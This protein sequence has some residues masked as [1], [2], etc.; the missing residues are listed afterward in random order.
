MLKNI[1]NKDKRG[2]TGGRKPQTQPA[3]GAGAVPGNVSPAQ[4][5]GAPTQQPMQM[6]A[7]AP[8]GSPAPNG[9]RVISSVPQSPVREIRVPEPSVTKFDLSGLPVY[10]I[11]LDQLTPLSSRGVPEV[12]VNIHMH[13][14]T[15]SARHE[16]H[17]AKELWTY[18]MQEREAA[19][20]RSRVRDFLIVCFDSRNHGERTTAPNAQKS[21]KEGNSTHAVDMYGMIRGTA[22]DT[23][24]ILEMLAPY[25]FPN[26]E[27]IVSIYTVTGKS[28]GGHS[29]WQVLAHEPRIKV[30][31]SLIGT[32]DFQKLIAMRAKK[33][34]LEDKPPVVPN[35]LRKLMQAEDPAETPYREPNASNPF[36]GKKICACNGEDDTLVRYSYSE[37]FYNHVL[38][39][40]PGSQDQRDGFMV[41]LQPST[42]HK[43]TSPML[44][45]GAHWLGMW[46]I[47]Y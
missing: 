19:K 43:V 20:Q 11:G 38:V 32:P 31:V 29:S 36:F 1:F 30:G 35:A 34:G 22:V 15:G 8:Q 42:G 9:M 23:T 46:A 41:F 40:P 2:K 25:M 13:G 7:A 27:R 6:A 17:L 39:G 28:L 33:S 14:R 45:V 5:S 44:Q 10:V 3:P 12:C 16:L 4:P 26:D 21:W 24:F 47:P 18:T 37:E